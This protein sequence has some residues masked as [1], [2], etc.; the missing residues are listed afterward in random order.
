MK[1][2][3]DL[4]PKARFRNLSNEGPL[5]F[6]VLAILALGSLNLYSST[7]NTATQE[8]GIFFGKQLLWSGVGLILLLICWRIQPS[9]WERFA[10]IFYGLT[11][12][13]LI[14]V[15]ISGKSAGG[16]QRWLALGPLNI[17]P[18]E[19]V[20]V[21]TLMMLARYFEK[22]WQ[23]Q[24][25]HLRDLLRPTFMIGL[26]FVLISMQP[27]L[28][29]A[30]ILLLSG[31]T[32]I[33][34]AGVH[35]KSVL[36][37]CSMGTGSLVVGWRFLLKTYQ[38]ERILNL[39]DPGR[40]PLGAGYHAIQSRIAIGSGRGT[41]KGFLEGTQ[42][43]LHFLPERHTDFAISVWGEEWGFL[44]ILIL[45]LLYFYLVY[46]GLETARQSRDRFG[47]FLSLGIT[48]LFFWQVMINASM[49][50]GMAPVVGIPLPLFSYGG[51]STLVL[52]GAIGILLSINRRR[53]TL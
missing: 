19:I 8:T 27:D 36:L 17:Q 18:S 31:M 23:I 51:S 33:L 52:L 46:L 16:S 7:Y 35:P 25:M 34:S 13:L 3:T 1:P 40:D 42:S 9:G 10:S 14:A 20:K 32:V 26:P 11:I 49:T 39:L 12:L 24:G 44:G 50:V 38:K 53:S 30:L 6:T 41:G 48:S 15:L 21:T 4:S 22:N 2:F 47:L 5:L 43:Q 45:L 37:L 28:G 29:T